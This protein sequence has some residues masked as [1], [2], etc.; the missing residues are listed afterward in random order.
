MQNRQRD[1]V[2][3]DILKAAMGEGASISRI[4]FRAYLSHG[5]AMSYVSRL[6]EDGMLENDILQG[7][8]YFK[9]TPQGVEYSVALDAMSELLQTEIRRTAS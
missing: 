9:T 4:M 6:V 8:M 3:R 7:R 5:Q 2:T 1:E